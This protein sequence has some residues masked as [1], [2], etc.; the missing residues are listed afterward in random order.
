LYAVKHDPFAYFQNIELGD[1]DELSLAQ[2][3]DFDGPDG[4]WWY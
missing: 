4:L 1:E 3:T 2:V